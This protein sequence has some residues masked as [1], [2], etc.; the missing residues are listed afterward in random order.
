MALDDI[1]FTKDSSLPDVH[2][3]QGQNTPPVHIPKADCPPTTPKQNVILRREGC[4]DSGTGLQQIRHGVSRN[5]ISNRMRDPTLSGKGKWASVPPPSP[6]PQKKENEKK[7]RHNTARNRKK[8]PI[9]Q[10][11]PNAECL[12]ASPLYSLPEEF[13]GPCMTAR[14]PMLFK[15][16]APR[17]KKKRGKIKENTKDAR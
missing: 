10:K 7:C 3:Y 14:R 5:P 15:R 11:K 8:T 6:K 9:L 12:S 13:L 2:H 4:P 16:L 17:A 1:C